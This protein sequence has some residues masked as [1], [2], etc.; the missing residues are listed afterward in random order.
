[1][2]EGVSVTE[3]VLREQLKH[4]QEMLEYYTQYLIDYGKTASDTRKK[5]RE[6]EV[7]LKKIDDAKKEKLKSNGGVAYVTK[8]Y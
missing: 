1:M 4:E 5:V 3:R 7:E 8:A 6:L 2:E